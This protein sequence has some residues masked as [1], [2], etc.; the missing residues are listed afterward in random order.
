METTLKHQYRRMQFTKSLQKA[1][2]EDLV[3]LV[4]DGVP[5][6]QAIETIRDINYG[7]SKDVAAEVSEQISKGAQLADGMKPWFT[8]AVVEIIRAGENSGMLIETLNAASKS[9][10]SD[11][12]NGLAVLS[13]VMYPVF[14][15]V[16][17]LVMIVFIKDSVLENF[18][19]IKSTV[20]WPV[21]G[22]DLF[23]L[24]SFFENWWWVLLIVV[25]A[26]FIGIVVSMRQV[27][28]D[29]RKRLDVLPFFAVYRGVVAARFMQTLGL[30]VNN[31]VVLKKAL[32]IMQIQAH[33]Y[34]AWHLLMMEY[35]LSGGEDNIADVLDT[36][37]VAREDLV[38]L[39]VVAIGKGFEPA[40]LTLGQQASDKIKKRLLRNAKFVGGVL[41]AGAALLAMMV[42]FGIY[43]IGSMIAS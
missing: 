26:A 19:D 7:I 14:I 31:G 42:V 27:T 23:G 28:G 33:P 11:V 9:I 30:L 43:S 1:F 5:A 6:S 2:L 24:A 10:A 36:G 37:L 3:S 38:R 35:R 40:L 41:L 20:L 32:E 16:L 12:N 39:R 13:A 15:V 25:L 4:N 29:L 17:A 21:V 34:L 8:T 18:A 22:Q